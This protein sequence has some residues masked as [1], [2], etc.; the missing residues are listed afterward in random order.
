MEGSGF[1]FWFTFSGL[2]L[3]GFRGLG[4]GFKGSGG[5]GIKSLRVSGSV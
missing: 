1:G 2:R 5:F 3:Q 4:K